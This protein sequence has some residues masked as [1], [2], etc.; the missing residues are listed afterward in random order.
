MDYTRKDIICRIN[1]IDDVFK[2]LQEL[3]A[4]I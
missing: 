2:V 1:F 4:S 3:E